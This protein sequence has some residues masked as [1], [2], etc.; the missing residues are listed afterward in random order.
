MN[1]M[2]KYQKRKV[3]GGKK[4]LKDPHLL[5]DGLTLSSKMHYSEIKTISNIQNCLAPPVIIIK[6]SR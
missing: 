4:E 2:V 5:L 1:K 6:I 3:N